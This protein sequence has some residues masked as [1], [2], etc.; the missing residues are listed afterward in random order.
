VRDGRF[1]AHQLLVRLGLP[2]GALRASFGVGTGAD[3]VERLA[4]AIERL[5]REGPRRQYAPG[6]EG[7]AP[8]GDD[9]PLPELL[10]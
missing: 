2:G 9:R 3:D 8:L 6:P 1:R 7:W 5:V 4:A 10:A